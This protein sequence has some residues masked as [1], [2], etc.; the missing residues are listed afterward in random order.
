MAVDSL[1]QTTP[2]QDRKWRWRVSQHKSNLENALRMAHAA[3]RRAFKRP[4]L[5]SSHAAER[6]ARTA[7]TPPIQIEGRPGSLP[8]PAQFD[9]NATDRLHSISW[10]FRVQISLLILRGPRATL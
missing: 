3:I 5:N 1:H 9:F 6:L 10:P 8:F 2:N 7:D 4:S